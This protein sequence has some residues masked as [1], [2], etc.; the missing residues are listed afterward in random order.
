MERE[1]WRQCQ[2]EALMLDAARIGM[3]LH[4]SNHAEANGE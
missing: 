3:L 4:A 1:R 2:H